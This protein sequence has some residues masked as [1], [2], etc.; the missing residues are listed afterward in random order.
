M[1][2]YTKIL[3]DEKVDSYVR[4][5]AAEALSEFGQAAARYIPDIANIL[6]DEKVASDVRLSAA[7]ALT[8]IRKLELKE[9]VI[10]LNNSY[11]PGNSEYL[12]WR[13]LTYFLGGG[14]EEVKTLLKWLGSPQVTP[15]KLSHDE[16]VKTLNVFLQTWNNSQG[17]ER[18][19]NDLA[20]QI[21][22][23]AAN[24][25]VFWKWQDIGLLQSHYSNLKKVN[26]TDAN[27]VQSVINHLKY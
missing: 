23:V 13:F 11:Q 6:K 17:L 26:P 7:V 8:N 24:K 1:I 21:S 15:D 2:Y 14:T 4:R 16:G 25:N 18:L 9:V 22:E 19:R 10:I 27:A 3:K 20:K 5:R 12:N